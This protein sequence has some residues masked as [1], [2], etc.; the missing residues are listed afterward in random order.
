M[1]ALYDCIGVAVCVAVGYRA[2]G[3]SFWSQFFTALPV[4]TALFSIAAAY[5]SGSRPELWQLAS[6]AAI[7]SVGM[8]VLYQLDKRFKFTH[9]EKDPE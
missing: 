1:E 5:E 4:A 6:F 8:V 9:W 7:S 3:P 2:F